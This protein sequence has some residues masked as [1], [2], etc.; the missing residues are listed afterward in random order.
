V[1]IKANQCI[2]KGV[3]NGASGTVYHIDWPAGTDFTLQP[4]STWLAST[5]PTNIYVDVHQCTM[6]APFPLL[7]P[8]W[9]ATVMPVY[10]TTGTVT[11]K[12]PSLSIRGF[13]LVPA[14]GTTVHGVQGETREAVAVTNLRPPSCRRVDSHALYV[15][16][17]R[18]RTRRGLHW[19]GD[20]PTQVD[21]DFFR[22]S[23][24]V[25]SEDIRLTNLS[26]STVSTFQALATTDG[27]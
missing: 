15:A 16:L 18:I 19:I 1:R 14:F 20:R 5:R 4:N 12:G 22:P 24:E 8:R 25:L 13:P 7:P 6:A 21:Y 10:E 3:V 23:T 17:S 26:A 11:M 9:A 2:P 27:A